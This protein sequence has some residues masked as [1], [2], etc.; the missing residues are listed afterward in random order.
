MLH[1]D[2]LKFHFKSIQY[3]TDIT[4]LLYKYRYHD[5]EP[6]GE[7]LGYFVKVPS[8]INVN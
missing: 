1:Y 4:L 2:N 8:L 6:V 3:V 5:R 7:Y